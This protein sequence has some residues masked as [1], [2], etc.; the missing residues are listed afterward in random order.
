MVNKCDEMDSCEGL[1]G[2]ETRQYVA[3]LVTQQVTG[4]G[5]ACYCGGHRECQVVMLL[6]FTVV[7]GLEHK[8]VWRLY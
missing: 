4:P 2:Q 6:F 1:D 7:A 5:G 8:P 3:D